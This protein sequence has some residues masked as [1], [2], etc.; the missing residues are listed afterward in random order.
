MNYILKHTTEKV[1]ITVTNRQHDRKKTRY[2]CVDSNSEKLLK[3]YN[4]SQNIIY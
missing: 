4:Q 2:L 3:E 1:Y